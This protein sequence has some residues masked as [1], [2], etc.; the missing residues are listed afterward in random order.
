M[1]SIEKISIALPPEMVSLVRQA[2][3]TGEYASSSEVV[4]EALREWSHRRTLRREGIEELRR[5]WQQ[6]ME[7][8]SPGIPAD[9]VL[10]RLE[11]KYQAIA[12]ASGNREECA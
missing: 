9:E 6:A 5:V 1:A 8:N 7:D 12:D 3:D 11:R 10:D 2:V 4:R